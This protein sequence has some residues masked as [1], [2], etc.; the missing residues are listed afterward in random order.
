MSTVLSRQTMLP[1]LRS[2]TEAEMVEALAS[3]GE[4]SYRGRQLARWVHARGATTFEGMTDLPVAL[5][6]KLGA[7]FRLTALEIRQRLVCP[8]GSTTKYLF[9]CPDGSTIESVWM[10]YADG[11]RS[12]CVSTQ[13]G[14]AMGCAFCATGLAGLTRNLTAGEMVDQ[15]Y[16]MVRDRGERP[17]HVVFMG[18][19]EPLANYEA[20]V[21]AVRLLNAPYGLGIGI[22]RITVST[23]GLVPQIRRLTE[24]E[25]DL[26]LA[27]SLHAATDELRALLVPLARRYPLGELL[28][29]CRFYITRTRRRITFE[30]VLLEGVNDAPEEAHALG[31][32]LRGMLCHLNLIPWNP[33]PGL[34]FRR[35]SV[36]RVQAFARAVR[37]YG[38]PTT[39]R[40]ERGTEIMAACGQL[41]RAS[42]PGRRP[43]R[44]RLRGGER[45]H[46]AP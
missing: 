12:V 2:M 25:L 1:D 16:A 45:I 18:M 13:V 11:R 37:A 10:R 28:E 4:L 6:G 7:H 17:T 9:A 42:T 30:Y 41:Y 22:R 24:E 29:A 20:T 27:V 38:I 15:V 26:T 35:P 46:D 5:R 43:T 40:V 33:V 19:G 31:R 39:V 34:A 32:L 3:M 21:R 14:C 23:V 8:D 44:I 36:E